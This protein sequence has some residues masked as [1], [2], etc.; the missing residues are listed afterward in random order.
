MSSPIEETKLTD[1]CKPGVPT[2]ALREV[3]LVLLATNGL[4][5]SELD[6]SVVQRIIVPDSDSELSRTEVSTQT[7]RRPLT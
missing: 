2:E 7:S 5:S 6:P 1:N 3:V 4:T